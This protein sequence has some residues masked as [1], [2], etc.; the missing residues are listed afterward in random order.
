MIYIPGKQFPLSR[1]VNKGIINYYMKNNMESSVFLE[2]TESR[3]SYDKAYIIDQGMSKHYGSVPNESYG[4][5]F[6]LGINKNVLI[7]AY[8]LCSTSGAKCSLLSWDFSVSND[9]INWTVVETHINNTILLSGEMISFVI[10]KP[11]TAKY[12]K[13]TNRGINGCQDTPM[14]IYEAEIFGIID[15]F[16]NNNS[17]KRLFNRFLYNFL[18]SNILIN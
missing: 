11:I 13:W 7:S 10:D 17:C 6:T 4:Q 15:P 5:Y 8:S 1:G 18:F 14:Y 12:F 3:G 2:A 9:N 16:I